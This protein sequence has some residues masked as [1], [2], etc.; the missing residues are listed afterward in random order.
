[1]V[2]RRGRRSLRV[3]A[4]ALREKLESRVLLHGGPDLISSVLVHGFDETITG[5]DPNAAP[6][7]TAPSDTDVGATMSITAPNNL[8][9]TAVGNAI[10]LTWNDRS[11]NETG[12]RIL[13]FDRPLHLFAGGGTGGKMR[14]PIRTQPRRAGVHLFVPGTGVQHGHHV[15][16]FQHHIGGHYLV[17]GAV[18]A[19][20][21]GIEQSNGIE[22]DGFV[23]G[24][25]FQ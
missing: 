14:R 25:Q 12:F 5:S 9:A 2:A 16:Q 3:A 22:P 8:L 17:S 1:M 10:N 18:L 24:Y 23:A 11:N 4:K 13:S 20:V 19:G 21:F 7:L 15:G 6:T